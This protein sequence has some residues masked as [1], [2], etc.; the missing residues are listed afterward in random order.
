MKYCWSFAGSALAILLWIT[1]A[2]A[3]DKPEGDVILTV[4]GQISETNSSSG[5]AFDMQMLSAL[6]QTRFE[7]TTRW[8][9][10]ATFDGVLLKDLLVAVGANGKEIVATALN[11]FSTTIPVE[12]ISEVPV[13]IAVRV[14]GRLMKVRDRGPLW[15]VYDVDKRPDLKNIHTERKMVWQLKDL[16]IR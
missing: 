12:D 5:A 7:T 8:T 13:L 16:T 15:I 10:K 6:P 11:D 2:A 1:P 9:D 14:N 4:K 3:L